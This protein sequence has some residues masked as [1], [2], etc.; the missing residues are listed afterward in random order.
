MENEVIKLL[1]IIA[2]PTI[3]IVASNI[4][5][6]MN[7]SK[8]IDNNNDRITKLEIELKTENNEIKIEIIKLASKI[9][10][11]EGEFGIVTEK[12]V[13]VDKQISEIKAA[14]TQQISEIKVEFKEDFAKQNEN[15]NARF[16]QVETENK[17]FIKEITNK[18]FDFFQTQKPIL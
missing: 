1:T 6:F 2:I 18:I 16:A 4:A 13:V 5:L 8:K 17:N 9:E 7:L 12:F 15:T 10:R 11:L 14:N 3:T